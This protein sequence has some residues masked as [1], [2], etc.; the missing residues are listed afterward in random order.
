MALLAVKT[1]QPDHAITQGYGTAKNGANTVNSL[2]REEVYVREFNRRGIDEST[3][4]RRPQSGMVRRGLW[5]GTVGQLK[6]TARGEA[7]SLA[8]HEV[9][10][11]FTPTSNTPVVPVYQTPR[12][13]PPTLICFC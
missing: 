10:Q 2:V 7:F 12:K 9:L 13:P 6:S 3:C 1:L 8:E 4:N 5:E 11:N